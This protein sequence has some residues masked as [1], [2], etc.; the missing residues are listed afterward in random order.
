MM[1]KDYEQIAGR[2][3]FQ[4]IVAATDKRGKDALKRFAEALA[5]DLECSNSNF[6]REKF[7]KASGV[8]A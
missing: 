7:L 3:K 5:Y 1:R 4:I 8:M 2:I 6:D